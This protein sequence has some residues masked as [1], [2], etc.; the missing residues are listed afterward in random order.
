[1]NR[2][3]EKLH[4]PKAQSFHE[5][6]SLET[7]VRDTLYLAWPATSLPEGGGAG[8]GAGAGGRGGRGGGIYSGNLTP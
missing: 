8:G 2:L 7:I 4:M 1:M 6:S 3:K 5:S